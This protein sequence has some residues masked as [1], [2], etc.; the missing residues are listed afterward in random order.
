MLGPR[1]VQFEL[2]DW[3]DDFS[4][5]LR[6]VLE[7]V[8]PPYDATCERF[9]EERRHVRTTSASQVRRPVNRDGTGRYCAHADFLEPLRRARMGLRWTRSAR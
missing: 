2:S 8:G 9:Y 4:G 1:L 6:R 7:F 5:T 3:A